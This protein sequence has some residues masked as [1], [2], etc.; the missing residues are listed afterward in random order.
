[1][2]FLASFPPKQ[3]AMMMVHD[4]FGVENKKKEEKQHKETTSKPSQVQTTF[5]SMD[6]KAYAN[7]FLLHRTWC[8]SL[9]CRIS[10]KRCAL[11]RETLRDCCAAR[12]APHGFCWTVGRTVCVCVC[13]SHLMSREENKGGRKKKT[14]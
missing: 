7:D 14:R 13:V 10:F 9:F 2:F 5:P 8:A 1:M 6:P 11:L 4:L 12:W 3:P